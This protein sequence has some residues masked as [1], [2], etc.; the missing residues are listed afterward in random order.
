M[1]QL[2]VKQNHYH[3]KFMEE[4][5]KYSVED[6][7]KQWKY[8]GGNTKRHLTKYET[9]FFKKPDLP[10][11]NKCICTHDIE[12]N[13][14]IKNVINEQIL[15]V[16]NCCINKFLNIDT[17]KKCERCNE[18]HKNKKNNYCNTCR[19]TLILSIGKYKGK[20]FDYVKV[21]DPL[22]CDWVLRTE[23]FGESLIKFKEWLIKTKVDD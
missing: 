6:I 3:I 8:I 21:N 14:Y 4:L 17:S 20:S 22:Y 10:H 15:I 9:L 12:E 11:S 1:N 13:C 23:I 2:K 16:G 5:T 19:Q 7:T 18:P